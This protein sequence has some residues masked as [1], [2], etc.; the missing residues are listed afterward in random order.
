MK[1]RF[2]ELD[3]KSFGLDCWRFLNDGQVV[4]PIY[5]SKSE[6]LADLQRYWEEFTGNV[7]PPKQA[8]HTPGPWMV[9]GEYVQTVPTREGFK[10]TIARIDFVSAINMRKANARLIAAAPEMLEAL[11]II[12]KDIENGSLG[13]AL[14]VARFNI[15]KAEGRS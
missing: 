15:A 8:T 7:T 10:S 14:S 4:G 13:N 6:I 12:V 1:T 9:D 5:K 3:V 2:A 11:K